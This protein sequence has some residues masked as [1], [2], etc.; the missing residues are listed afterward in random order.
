MKLI[1]SWYKKWSVHLLGLCIFIA[2]LA[3]Y[4]PEVEQHL[5][6]NWYRFAFY[7]ILAAR[8]IRQKS[9]GPAT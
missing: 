2:E 6:A 7:A 4:L 3:P 9:D 1:E 8:I 5:P